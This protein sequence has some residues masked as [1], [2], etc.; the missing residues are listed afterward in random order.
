[1]SSDITVPI[2]PNRLELS[3]GFP[4]HNRC[5]FHDGQ[6]LTQRDAYSSKVERHLVKRDGKPWSVR[7]ELHVCLLLDRYDLHLDESKGRML[8]VHL[9]LHAFG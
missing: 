2:H 8:H 6:Q 9:Q 1:M 7:G 4:P 3:H 5:A